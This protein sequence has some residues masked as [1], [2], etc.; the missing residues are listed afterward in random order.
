M[1]LREELDLLF[2][3]S[4]KHH[5][6]GD[7]PMIKMKLLFAA[8]M[9]LALALPASGKTYKTTYATPCDELWPAVK[10]TL[11]NADNCKVLESDDS[12]MTA[13]YNVKHSAHFSIAGAALQRTNR[14]TL[15]AKGA[16]CEMQVVSNYSGWEH[17]DQGDFKARVEQ[18]LDKLKAA[19]PA[20]PAKSS[21]PGK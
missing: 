15:V 17:N 12:K 10:D 6:T 5:G 8:V 2:W 9:A 19:K 1:K 13:S 3:V 7:N 14:V 20:Q 4:K 11:S 18:S 16:G 21:D